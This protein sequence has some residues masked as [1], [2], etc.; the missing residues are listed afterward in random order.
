MPP[1]PPH[2]QIDHGFTLI[3]VLVALAVIAIGLVA[4]MAVAARSGRVDSEL[5]QRTFAAWVASNQ[6]ERMRLDSKWPGLGS[7][8]GKITL[9]DQDWHWKATVAK[10]EDPDL[11]RVTLSVATEAKPDDP[12]TQL[13][14]FLGRPPSNPTSLP[15]SGANPAHPN[16]GGR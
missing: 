9:A 7:S 14:G 11:R 6:M 15:G 2:R 13:L 4:V 12:V 8:D 3:E 16:Q 10:T 1:A 5:Q